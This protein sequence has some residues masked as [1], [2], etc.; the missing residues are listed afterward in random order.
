[1]E[2]RY[3]LEFRQGTMTFEPFASFDSIHSAYSRYDNVIRVHSHSWE[4]RIRDT[5]R[6]LNQ[7]IV[8]GNGALFIR[9]TKT[10]KG[11]N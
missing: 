10:E 7:T 6:D 11:R 8:Q 5:K 1:M 9:S 4:F 3:Q 2:K